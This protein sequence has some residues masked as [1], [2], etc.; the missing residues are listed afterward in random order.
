MNYITLSQ[1]QPSEMTRAKSTLQQSKKFTL[2]EQITEGHQM[3]PPLTLLPRGGEW[4]VLG[5]EGCF[6]LLR[7]A[8]SFCRAIPLSIPAHLQWVAAEVQSS[9][10]WVP[11]SLCTTREPWAGSEQDTLSSCAVWDIHNIYY[12]KKAHNLLHSHNFSVQ[13]NVITDWSEKEIESC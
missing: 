11:S 3:D 1:I 12:F 7:T 5:W 2:E 9:P 13:A 8:D 10:W 4:L 6:H